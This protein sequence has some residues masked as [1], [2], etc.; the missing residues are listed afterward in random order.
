MLQ[1]HMKPGSSSKN[2]FQNQVRTKWR[3]NVGN[4]KLWV[5][6]MFKRGYTAK[7]PQKK[8]NLK[9]NENN[10]NYS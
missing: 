3:R 4:L 6:V 9:I 1:I 8:V 7:Y 2:I 5:V 10:G